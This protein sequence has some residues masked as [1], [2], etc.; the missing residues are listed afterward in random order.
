MASNIDVLVE[1]SNN[2]VVIDD[3]ELLQKSVAKEPET[4]QKCSV[5]LSYQWKIQSKVRQIYN[6]LATH[7]CLDI[8]MDIFKLKAGMNLYLT[9]ASNIQTADVVLACVTRDYVN[10]KNCEREIIYADS[11]NKHIIPL[12]MEK[13]P[14]AEL[15][16]IGFILVRERYCNLYK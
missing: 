1:K 14:M 16:S 13:I 12:Y 3:E 8:F 2:C 9:L 5:F 6:E 4:P 10:S 11:F 15:G 7:E